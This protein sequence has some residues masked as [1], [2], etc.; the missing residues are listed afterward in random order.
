MKILITGGGG[1]VGCELTQALLNENHQVTSLDLYLYG[2]D[3]MPV[4]KNFTSI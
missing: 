4:N 2:E 1:Y 3:V